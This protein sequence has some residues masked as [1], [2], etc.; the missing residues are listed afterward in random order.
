MQRIQQRVNGSRASDS[1]SD[2]KNVLSENKDVNGN[3]RKYKKRMGMKATDLKAAIRFM[4]LVVFVFFV[5]ILVETYVLLT[6]GDKTKGQID[7]Q[8]HQLSE[9]A[10]E[11]VTHYVP[12]PDEM[13]DIGDKSPHYR[14][15]REIYDKKFPAETILS[16][17]SFI[18]ELR[19]RSYK[20]IQP[21]ETIG[22]DVFNCPDDPPENY[23]FEY[24]ILDVLNN[25][26]PDNPTPVTE[27]YQ[28]ICV[29]QYA[30]EYDKAVRY[31]EAEVPFVIRDDP[32]VLRTVERWNQPEYLEKILGDEPHRAEYSENNHFM[33]WQN[34]GKGKN[35]KNKGGKPPG[36]RA[37]TENIRMTYKD[38]LSKANVTD[39][40]KLGPDMPHWYFRLIAC[41]PGLGENCDRGNSELVFDELTIFQPRPE[42]TLYLTKP[43]QQKGIHC[44]FGMKGVIA[45]NFCL[46]YI[47]YSSFEL[48]RTLTIFSQLLFT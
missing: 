6:D 20:P 47:I 37:P 19:K 39:D 28:G 44:R 29:F 40:S 46:V 18:D 12:R 21:V 38:W 34:P 15:I 10:P 17:T 3:K 33:Y 41:G 22:Y 26:N 7:I 11:D 48:C 9:K 43:S 4:S 16:R 1:S 31:R 24:P 45:G 35:K 13:A 36:W 5:I 2:P 32:Q 8:H 30:T 14:R 23:P 27:I 42:E 25:W